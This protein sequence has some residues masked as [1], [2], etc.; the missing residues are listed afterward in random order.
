MTG[1]SFDY[2]R[3]DKNKKVAENT[4]EVCML[5]KVYESIINF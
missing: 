4:I 2:T 5:A 1:K 3:S